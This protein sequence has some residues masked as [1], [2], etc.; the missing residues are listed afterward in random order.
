MIKLKKSRSKSPIN[1]NQ[2][3]NVI[4][5]TSHDNYLDM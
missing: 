5:V 2:I 1:S 3:L 4:C